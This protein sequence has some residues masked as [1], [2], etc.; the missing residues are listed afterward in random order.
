MKVR[1][2]GLDGLAIRLSTR[3]ASYELTSALAGRHQAWNIATAVVAAE[4]FEAA[5]LPAISPAAI[6]AGISAC[7]WPGRLEALAV[8]G[9]RTTVLLDAAHNPAGCEALAGFLGEHGAALLPAGRDAAI[10]P[11]IASALELAL[12]AEDD[13]V[14]ACGSIF[15]IGALRTLLRERQTCPGC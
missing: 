6:A 12:G 3:R 4:Q 8:T 11:R 14:V 15:L 5:G 2:R 7:R 1:F 9:S 13:L 10:E